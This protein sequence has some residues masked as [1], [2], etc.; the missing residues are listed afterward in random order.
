M[1]VSTDKIVRRTI[2]LADRMAEKGIYDW[3]TARGALVKILADLEK[4]TPDEP[5]LALLR[6]YI[7]GQDRLCARRKEVS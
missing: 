1:S 2:R 7:A 4:R 3:S 5:S 6:D